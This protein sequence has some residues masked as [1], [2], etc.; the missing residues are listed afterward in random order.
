MDDLGN[1]C[2]VQ[3]VLE[4]AVQ[5]MRQ[6]A[7]NCQEF[8]DI[9]Q[10]TVSWA[11]RSELAPPDPQTV[12]RA[13]QYNHGRCTAIP[14][15]AIPGFNLQ[16][17]GIVMHVSAGIVAAAMGKLRGA[18]A[19]FNHTPFGWLSWGLSWLTHAILFDH[20]NYATH[21][22]TVADWGFRGGGLRAFASRGSGGGYG[23]ILE[24][25]A[26]R[27]AGLRGRGMAAII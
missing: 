24:P 7:Q 6:Q 20:G 14:G 4:E 2:C 16:V 13:A 22:T 21:S 19:A 17:G 1:A 18:M 9:P 10:E 3:D 23:A 11:R 26:D 5:V 15:D 12:I 25:P 27:D 8:A